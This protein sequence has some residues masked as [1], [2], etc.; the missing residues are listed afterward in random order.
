MGP[1]I[2]ARSSY[3]P[4]PSEESLI[5]FDSFFV[6]RLKDWLENVP[7]EVCYA[8][9]AVPYRACCGS[10]ALVQSISLPILTVR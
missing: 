3:A 2:C 7:G 5:L 9:C 8:A 4:K 10:Y 6:T 1:F